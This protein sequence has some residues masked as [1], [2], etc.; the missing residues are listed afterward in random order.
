MAPELIKGNE[1]GYK[2]DVWSLGIMMMEM[3]EGCP[4]YME[5]PPLRALF[6]ITTKGIPPLQN[7]NSFST[8]IRDFLNSCLQNEE[9]ARPSSKELLGH[10]FIK[11][12]CLP[13][14]FS[15]LIDQARKANNEKLIF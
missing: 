11:K 5:C 8:D 13:N 6:L 4:P 15:P 14:E 1:Y 3:L 7:E 9:D 12:S 2:V 10:V